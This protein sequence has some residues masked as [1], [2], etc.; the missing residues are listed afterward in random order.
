[1]GVFLLGP[2]AP[3]VVPLSVYTYRIPAGFPSPA[4]DHVEGPISLDELMDLRAPHTYLA[5]AAGHSMVGV[6]IGDGDILVIDRSRLPEPGQV[7]I[8]ALNGDPLVKIYDLQQGQ[9]ILRSANVQFPPRYLL[10]GDELAVW[11]VVRYSIRS[12][13]H[14]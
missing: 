12:H 11:G 6:G 7:V 4:Q 1:M 8:A 9:T 2:A 10:E 5:R 3:S 13:D 14:Y